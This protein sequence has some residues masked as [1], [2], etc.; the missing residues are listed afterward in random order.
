MPLFAFSGFFLFLLRHIVLQ[1]SLLLF[2]RSKALH[3]GEQQLSIYLVCSIS[4]LRYV[5]PRA[6]LFTTLIAHDMIVA[7]ST[8]ETTPAFSQY[9]NKFLLHIS[10]K[11]SLNPPCKDSVLITPK[12]IHLNSTHPHR[13]L[14][15]K[16]H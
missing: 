3:P 14:Y 15:L 11:I 1:I 9:P 10:P 4:L 16:S 12:L 8:S 5:K 6:F 7:N 13:P 2:S